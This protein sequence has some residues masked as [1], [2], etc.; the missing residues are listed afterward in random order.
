MKEVVHKTRACAIEGSQISILVFYCPHHH[1][2]PPPF[3]T[4]KVGADEAASKFLCELDND[5]EIGDSIDT[6][7]DYDEE[8]RQFTVKNQTLSPFIYLLKFAL[9]AIDPRYDKLD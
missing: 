5:K 2:F 7:N 4:F 3:S 1:V 9:G 8:A 6:V